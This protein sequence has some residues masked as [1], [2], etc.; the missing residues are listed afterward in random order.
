MR[1]SAGSH[2]PLRNPA[3]RGFCRP[4]RGIGLPTVRRLCADPDPRS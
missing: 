1:T 3:L 2:A 4:C